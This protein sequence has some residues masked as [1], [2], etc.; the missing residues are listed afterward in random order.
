M[1]YEVHGTGDP[2]V[3]L[4]GGLSTIDEFHR[5]LPALAQRRRVIAVER[6]GHGRTADVDRPFRLEQWADDTAALLRQ[7]GVGPADVFGYSTGGSV[8]LAMAIRH[9]ELVRKLVLCS[10]VY[11][12][13]GYHPEV[14][15]GLKHLTADAL[16]PQ[17]RDAYQREAPHPQDWPRLVAKAAEQARSGAGLQPEAIRGVRAPALVIVAERDVVRAEH[18]EELSRLLHAELVVLPDSDHSSYLLE[19]A[20]VLLRKLV[21]FLDAPVES[22]GA[23]R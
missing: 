21:A 8:A 4:H 3:M 12:M 5:V 2:L 16:P 23:P 20:E 7:Q 22:G 10:A 13:D 1:Y 14:R 18:A 15:E 17:M 6:Q 9:P 11:S 19:H